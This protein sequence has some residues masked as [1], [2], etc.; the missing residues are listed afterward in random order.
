MQPPP[1]V[2]CRCR[3]RVSGR[4]HDQQQQT[5]WLRWRDR[6]LWMTVDWVVTVGDL[7]TITGCVVFMALLEFVFWRSAVLLWLLP[8]FKELGWFRQCTSREAA[9]SFAS[10]AISFASVAKSFAS[11]ENQGLVGFVWSHHGAG[12]LRRREAACVYVDLQS[13]IVYNLRFHV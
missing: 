11:G 13:V 7:G 9:K 3:H 4:W 5:T 10:V 1:Q 6:R 8:G 2:V 12:D